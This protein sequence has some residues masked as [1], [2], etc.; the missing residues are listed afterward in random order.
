MICAGCR[1]PASAER[2]I[3]NC[4]LCAGEFCI[5]C[6]VDD[7]GWLRLKRG[8]L[9]GTHGCFLCTLHPK[10]VVKANRKCV[11]DGIVH[12]G[13][14][15]DDISK[16]LERLRHRLRRKQRAA[17]VADANRTGVVSRA[18]ESAASATKSVAPASGAVPT[19]NDVL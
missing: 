9:Y 18:S 12:E 19:V 14:D 10:A 16:K 17:D 5:E 15:E 11:E 2:E 1:E 4:A 6:I 3:Q 13:L 7:Y 8:E